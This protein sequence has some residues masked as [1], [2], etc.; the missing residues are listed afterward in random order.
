MSFTQ[1]LTLPEK[2]LFLFFLEATMVGTR[3]L[4]SPSPNDFL[5]F[6]CADVDTGCFNES[7]TRK[8]CDVLGSN[9]NFVS[10]LDQYNLTLFLS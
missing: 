10:F 2:P 3:D 6:P 1:L 9:L 4:P 5:F 8:T 7:C